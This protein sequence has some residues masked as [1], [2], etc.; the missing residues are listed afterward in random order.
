MIKIWETHIPSMHSTAILNS[1]WSY[2]LIV[3]RIH[4][5]LFRWLKG[6]QWLYVVVQV[7]SQT[8]WSGTSLISTSCIWRK[9]CRLKLFRWNGPGGS[10][11]GRGLSLSLAPTRSERGAYSCTARWSSPSGQVLRWK[12]NTSLWAVTGTFIPWQIYF[13]SSTEVFSHH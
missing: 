11:L 7:V 10:P 1:F 6:H 8:P 9:S 3:L 4:F 12:K 2:A 5:Q 13:W